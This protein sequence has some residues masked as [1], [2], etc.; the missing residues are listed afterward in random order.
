[1]TAVIIGCVTVNPDAQDAVAEY[2]RITTP[3]LERVGAKVVQSFSLAQGIVGEK[4]AEQIMIVEYPDLNAV[5]GVFQSEE[6]KQLTPVR[7]RAF[8]TYNISLVS[9]S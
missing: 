5:D 3:L 9:S 8:K 7:D 2:M 4:P 1:M 6:Y